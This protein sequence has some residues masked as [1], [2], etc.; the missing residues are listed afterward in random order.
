[1]NLDTLFI[2][3]LPQLVIGEKILY[4]YRKTETTTDLRLGVIL[5]R[6]RLNGS[7]SGAHTAMLFG[8]G[9]YVEHLREDQFR[10]GGVSG[11]V[12]DCDWCLYEEGDVPA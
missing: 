2:Q 3:P 6:A 7:P 9:A 1:M 5:P 12:R 11:L 4:L 8:N 10:E